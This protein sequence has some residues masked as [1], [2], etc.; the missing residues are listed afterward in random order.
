MIRKAVETL[1]ISPDRYFGYWR[2]HEGKHYLPSLTEAWPFAS[3]CYHGGRNEA[4]YLGYTPV[5]AKLYD[6]DLTSAYSTAMAMIKVPDWEFAKQEHEIERL[7]VVSEAMTFARVRFSFPEGTRFPALPVRAGVRGLVYPLNGTSWC[8]G[9][10]R[11]SGRSRRSSP[12][13]HGSD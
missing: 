9:P 12:A 11:N 5:G 3:N 7:A 8:T 10:C 1:G 13:R 4:F 2:H 6:I